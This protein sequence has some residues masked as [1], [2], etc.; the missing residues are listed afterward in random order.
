M[1][2]R[3]RPATSVRWEVLADDSVSIPVSEEELVC[4]KR[5]VVRERVIVGQHTVS[6]DCGVAADPLRSS[7]RIVSATM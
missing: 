6:D 1:A 7:A 3:M 5:L 2:E 4:E